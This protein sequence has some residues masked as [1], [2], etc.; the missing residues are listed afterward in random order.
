MPLVN[1]YA[2]GESRP[3]LLGAL[4]PLKSTS[5]IAIR[6]GT[7]LAAQTVRLE[8]LSGDKQMTG[9]SGR[10]YSVDAMLLGYK[11][12]PGVTDTNLQAGDTFA[13]D[14]VSFEVVA[15][16]PGHTDCLQAMLTMRS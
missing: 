13:V 9:P 15:I 12:Y 4:I 11:N 2:G 1:A 7:A 8:T 5:I 14:G 16:L 3:D 10:T 6:N